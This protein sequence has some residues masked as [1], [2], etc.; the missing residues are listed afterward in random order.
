MCTGFFFW[1]LYRLM[2]PYIRGFSIP[3][4][5]ILF[6]YSLWVFE[7]ISSFDM[8]NKMVKVGPIDLLQIKNPKLDVGNGIFEFTGTTFYTGEIVF[9]TLFTITIFIVA[10]VLFEKKVRL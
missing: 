10:T 4:T 5:I 7:R 3:L 9:D 1:V 2:V 8:Y 6:F